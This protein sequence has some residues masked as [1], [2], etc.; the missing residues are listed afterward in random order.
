[1]LPAPGRVVAAGAFALCALAGRALAGGPEE[2]LPAAKETAYRGRKVVVDFGSATPQVTTM[3]VICQPGG[4]ERRE[5]HATHGILVHDGVAS[6]QYFPDRGVVLKRPGRSEGGEVLRPEQLRR[7]LPAYEVRLI[8][9]GTVAGR[10]S[11]ALEFLP[12]ERG[13]R[14]RRRVWVDADTGLVLRT[15]VYDA[16][17]RLAWLSVFEALEYRP[18]LPPGAFTMRVPPGARVVE[19]GA[20]PCLEPEE[21]ERRSGLPAMLP[22]YLPGGFSRQCIQAV[23]RPGY[24]EIQAVYGDGLTLLSFFSSSKFRDPG[25]AGGGAVE[26]GPWPGRWHDLGLVR[27]ITWRAPWAHLALLGELSRGELQRIAASVPA[28]RETRRTG[29]RP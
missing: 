17:D 9:A 14:P 22:A 18:Q 27:G 4:R 16:D 28:P 26:I 15:E 20:D 11:R 5:F 10:A 19:A 13:T 6:W 1:M 23:G 7:T 3:S 21:A 29:P 25:G 8:A 12:R 24:G 2:L